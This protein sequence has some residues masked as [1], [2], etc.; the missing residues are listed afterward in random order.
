[1]IIH[2]LGDVP[3]P[4]IIGRLSELSSLADAVLIIPVAIAISG[5]IWTYAAWQGTRESPV[6]AP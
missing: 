4:A 2:L 6:A 1:M 5:L 3:S